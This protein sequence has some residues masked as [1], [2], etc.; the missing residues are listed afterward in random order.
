ML[1]VENEN[2]KYENS[3]RNI[4]NKKIYEFLLERGRKGAKPGEISKSVMVKF[5]VKGTKDTYRI[6]PLSKTNRNVRLKDLVKQKKIYKEKGHYFVNDPILLD[7]HNFAR[8]MK[9]ACEMMLKKSLIDASPEDKVPGQHTIAGPGMFHIHFFKALAGIS[10]SKHF[11]DTKFDKNA[12]N[13][14]Y[15]F[16]FAN[17][18]GAYITYLL[19]ES[20]RPVAGE[21][22]SITK[23]ITRDINGNRVSRRDMISSALVREGI[24][25]KSIF[26]LFL[27]IFDSFIPTLP[28]TTRIKNPTP[29]IVHSDYYQLSRDHFD[30]L[31]KVFRNVYPGVYE[32]LEKK[33]KYD[34]SSETDLL[35]YKER[36]GLIKCA[37]RWEETPIYKLGKF[38]FCRKCYNFI[39]DNAMQIR[40]GITTRVCIHKW[41]ETSLGS[42]KVYSCSE[43][44]FQF[45]VVCLF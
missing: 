45:Q 4:H 41:E 39:S 24:E 29:K 33:W 1:I 18:I 6:K 22:D 32:A 31:S 42:G 38:H 16:E 27:N 37:H 5:K 3:L 19:I 30:R 20:M 7:V 17:R 15:L 2:G 35:E 44:H 23:E 13:E 8:S 25:I 12:L 43:C 36:E 11:C 21:T 28:N 34:V 26:K 10:P 14:K 40:K 9:G